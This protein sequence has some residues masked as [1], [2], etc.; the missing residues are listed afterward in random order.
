MK[1]FF[2]ISFII[3]LINCSFDNKSGIWENENLP[4]KKVDNNIFNDFEKIS[5]KDSLFNQTILPD[6]NL[7]LYIPE[8]SINNNWKDI[9][10]N[11][12]NNSI[13]FSYENSNQVILKSKRLSKNKVGN[14]KL[15]H[16]GNLIISDDKGSLII[17]STYENQIIS[18]FN[19]Y[20][21]KFKNIKKKLN[22]IVENDI[23][24][25]SD[26][27][28]YLYAFNYKQSKLIWAKNFKIPFSS[29]LKIIKEKLI[30]ANQNNSLYFINKN[31]GEVLKL[32][33]T[34]ESPIKNKFTNNLSSDGKNNL[35]F[36]N[37]FG[38][39]YSIDLNKI[40][41]NW[42]NNLNQSFDLSPSNLFEGNKLVS[43]DNQ[44]I[45][46][47]NIKTYIID[48]N[49]G[50]IIKRYNFSSRVKPIIINDILFFLSNNNFLITLDLNTKKI[51]Y[52]FDLNELKDLELSKNQK[53]I[54]KDMMILNNDIFIFLEN[55]KILK[56]N[57]LGQFENLQKLPSNIQTS[58]ILIDSSIL[59]LNK[60]NKLIILN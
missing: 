1:L 16:N 43:T 11:S 9:F 51:L 13:N 8:P 56:F 32:L 36:L 14:Y 2:I 59:Y 5:I 44:I 26:N 46:S 53:N 28:G 18:K 42:F 12:K 17:F 33:P 37:S 29:N 31:N 60:K 45:V 20:K 22:I 4:K 19:F 10:Y 50:S 7:K 15:Y 57:I 58:P 6:T 25:V 38:S 27:L 52:S 40:T 24:F 35:F 30:L 41:I 34:E 3:L 55:S 21:K 48:T 54:F 39:L 23:I 47:S 49:T